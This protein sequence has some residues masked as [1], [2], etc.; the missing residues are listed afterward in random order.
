MAFIIGYCAAAADVSRSG[1]DDIASELMG[2]SGC[3]LDDLIK[4][5]VED[6][7]LDE[8]KKIDWSDKVMKTS[9]DVQSEKDFKNG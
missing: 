9:P 8:I 5:G 6:Y 1:H 4:A 2:N 3:S 7:D